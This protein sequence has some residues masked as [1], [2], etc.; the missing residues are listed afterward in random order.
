[1]AT[2]TAVS[3]DRAANSFTFDA[4][5]SGG[6][7]FVNTGTELLLIKHTNG[8]GSA[9]TLTIVTTREVDGQSVAD[10]EITIGAGETH[11]LGPFP[12]GIY[13]DPDEKVSFSYDDETDIEV[14]VI[15]P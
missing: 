3:P 13:N 11:L 1:M 14:A 6:D 2:I 9:V 4:A 5:A 12:T 10:K 7:D 8:A 15:S